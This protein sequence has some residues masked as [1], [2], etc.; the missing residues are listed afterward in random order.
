[1]GRH[2]REVAFRHRRDFFTL[3]DTARIR[4]SLIINVIMLVA[5]LDA[6]KNWQLSGAQTP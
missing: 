6:I 1:M 4:D 2:C 5:P 3:Q